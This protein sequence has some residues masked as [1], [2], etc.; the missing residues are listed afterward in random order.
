VSV[1]VALPAPLRELAGGATSVDLPGEPATVR[2]A[3]E[4]LRAE[5]RVVYDRILDERGRIRP[6][7]N[8][9]VGTTSVRETG[10]LDTRLAADDE[11]L[12]LPS[13]SGG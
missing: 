2:E 6:H 7:V 3:L 8:L 4:A 11:I 9:F 12:V 1:S 5:H 10:G 13:V